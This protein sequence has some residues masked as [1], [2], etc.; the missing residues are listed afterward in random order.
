[1]VAILSAL[2]PV[3]LITTPPPTAAV[4]PPSTAVRTAVT[5]QVA[6]DPFVAEPDPLAGFS[7]TF[8]CR[9]ATAGR[10][11]PCC[12]DATSTLSQFWT[13]WNLA[14]ADYVAGREGGCREA[15]INS[16]GCVGWFQ[17]CGWNC[18][19][20]C[21]NGYANAEKAYWLWQQFG[22][23]STGS[24]Y[25]AGDPVTGRGGVACD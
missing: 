17:L 7:G 24:W 5:V 23:C 4:A 19:G 1:M 8:R 22:W 6:P 11:T 9:F 20:P 18:N 21:T 12:P 3:P 14:V 15:I 10:V 25:L 2:S 13:G 16:S